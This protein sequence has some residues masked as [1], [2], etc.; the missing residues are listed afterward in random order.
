TNNILA[1]HQ[2]IDSNILKEKA[3]FFVKKLNINTFSQ[4]EEES[5]AND[6]TKLQQLLC[7]YEF[8]D[9]W[10]VNETRLF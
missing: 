3:K 7:A 4:S 5:I 1:I 9:I 8:Q 2:D 6:H 10:N